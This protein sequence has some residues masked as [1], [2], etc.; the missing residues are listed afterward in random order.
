MSSKLKIGSKTKAATSAKSEE[1]PR[2]PGLPDPVAKPAAAPEPADKPV[3]YGKGG[4]YRS[5]GGGKRV[6]I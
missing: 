6:R 2:L 1:Q 5:I 3:S 4:V